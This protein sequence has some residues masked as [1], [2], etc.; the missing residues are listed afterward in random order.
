MPMLQGLM[1]LTLV[2]DQ[3]SIFDYPGFELWKFVN[4]AIFVGA[5]F[6]LHRVLG[7]PVRE[8]FRARKERI[9]RE[10]ETARQE[11]DS[12]LAQLSEVETRLKGLDAE[13]AAIAKKALAESQAEYARIQ[14]ATNAEVMKLRESARREIEMAGKAAALELRRIAAEESLRLAEGVI[15]REIGPD[16]ETRLLNLRPDVLGGRPN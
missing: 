15:R 13:T 7:H 1:L 6:Y 14:E 11:R 2:D 16:D 4:L 3:P 8:A 12:A 5:A 9:K 10:L